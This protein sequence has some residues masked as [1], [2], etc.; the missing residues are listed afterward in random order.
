MQ[1]AAQAELVVLAHIV[2]QLVGMDLMLIIA[3]V[4]DMLGQDQAVVLI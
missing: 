4:A 1:L 3:I 2:A